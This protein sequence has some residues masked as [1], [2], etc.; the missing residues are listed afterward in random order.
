MGTKEKEYGV[1][2]KNALLKLKD[3]RDK[4]QSQRTAMLGQVVTIEEKSNGNVSLSFLREDG[5]SWETTQFICSEDH[6]VYICEKLWP[7]IASIVSP[8]DRLKLAKN[9]NL[10]DKLKTITKD[11]EVGFSDTKDV[12]LGKVKYIGAVKGMGHCYGIELHVSL[13][14]STLNDYSC[15]VCTTNYLYLFIKLVKVFTM[16]NQLVLVD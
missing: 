8:Q 7:F 15:H 6:I 3:V 10:C 14:S 1:F 5:L 4:S 11:M 2:L 16:N 9:K 13:V 12:Y